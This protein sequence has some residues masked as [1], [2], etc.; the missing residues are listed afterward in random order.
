M[1]LFIET[2]TADGA[3]EGVDSPLTSPSA[4]AGGA[5]GSATTVRRELSYAHGPTNPVRQDFTVGHLQSAIRDV[6]GT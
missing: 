2:G 3:S 6:G 4:D 1:A 5:R